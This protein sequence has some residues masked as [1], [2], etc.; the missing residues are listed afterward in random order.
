MA[1]TVDDPGDEAVRNAL[2]TGPY[3]RCV[4][5][6]DNDVVDNQTVNLEFEDGITATLTTNAFGTGGRY[7]R[8]FGTKGEAFMISGD[9]FV[10]YSFA[11]RAEKRV[12]ASAASGNTIADGHGGGDTGIMIDAIRYL[13]ENVSSKSICDVRMSYMSHLIAF[14]AEE[15]RFT[16]KI[17]DLDDYTQSF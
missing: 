13:G 10:V 12:K 2:L 7:V 8:V 5:A 1:G 11:D 6:C 3:G 14:A 15:S 4:Y 16:G 9:E 17:V